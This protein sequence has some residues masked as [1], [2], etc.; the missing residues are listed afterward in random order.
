MNKTQY[1]KP[2]RFC[3]NSFRFFLK[4]QIHE[5]KEMLG[6]SKQKNK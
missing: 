5:K 1:K 6:K 3:H 4:R 2:C